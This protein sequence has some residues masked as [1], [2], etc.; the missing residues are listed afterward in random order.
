M[1]GLRFYPTVSAEVADSSGTFRSF[2]KYSA[3]KKK[4]VLSLALYVFGNAHRATEGKAVLRQAQ[5]RGLSTNPATT[6]TGQK[7][8]SIMVPSYVRAHIETMK[9]I[10]GSLRQHRELIRTIRSRC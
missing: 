9:K 6:P 8:S 5:C 10:A 4:D 3:A 2:P 1:I 7:S